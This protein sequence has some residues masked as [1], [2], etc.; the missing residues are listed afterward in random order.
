[1]AGPFANTS[2]R[3]PDPANGKL[4]YTTAPVTAGGRETRRGATSR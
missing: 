4:I 1:M 2:V 3:A